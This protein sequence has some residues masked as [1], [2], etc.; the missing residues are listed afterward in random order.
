VVNPFWGVFRRISILGGAGAA[1]CGLALASPSPVFAQ[2]VATPPPAA[3][4]GTAPGV[5]PASVTSTPDY[6]SRV[7]G[8]IYESIP[9]TREELGEYLI[10]RFGAERLELLA[11]KKI[12]EIE[13]KKAGVEVT[14]AEVEERLNNDLAGLSV[15]R[16]TFVDQV[17]KNYKKSLYEW[18]EDV[19]RPQLML[20]KL[21]RSR[22]KVTDEDLKKA[23][24]AYHGEKVDCRLIMWSKGEEKAA[25]QA[26]GRIRD[27]EEE[28]NRA[29][30]AQKSNTLASAGGKI[31]PISRNT[32]GN[33]E[34]EKAAFSLQ[35]GEV[36]ALVG[37]PEGIVCIKCDKRIPADTSVAMES[38]KEKLSKEIF[39]KKVNAE[40]PVVF[41]EMRKKAN[42]RL[43]MGNSTEDL[44][45]DVKELLEEPDTKAGKVIPTGVTKPVAPAGATP[46]A[47]P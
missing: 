31:R 5:L 21:V 20:A 25:M 41:A 35:A 30:R 18:K 15:D 3:P 27:S 4:T 44:A 17:L 8:Y 47:K 46:P 32:T 6:S 19:L 43:L 29:A 1:A 34:L 26:Y 24:D 7:V 23:Y 2:K 39:E 9:I 16:K 40:I 33:E 28:F 11:N 13:C 36:S 12:I 42:P 10:T 14:G 38:V 37:T 22:V 45:K